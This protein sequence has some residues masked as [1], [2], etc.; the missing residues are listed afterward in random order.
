[1]DLKIYYDKIVDEIK[2]LNF[3]IIEITEPAPEKISPHLEAI[4]YI[5]YDWNR[6]HKDDRDLEF[7]YVIQPTTDI[8]FTEVSFDDF[9]NF[10]I[11][12]KTEENILVETKNI[13]I[14]KIEEDYI[15]FDIEL[16]K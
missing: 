11:K 10:I 7:E 6:D 1:V 15:D 3:K 5:I 14:I 12:I 2:S 16:K 13:E 9:F 4:N 8:D